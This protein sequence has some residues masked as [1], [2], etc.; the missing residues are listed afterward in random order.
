MVLRWQWACSSSSAATRP[1]LSRD[2]PLIFLHIVSRSSLGG[3]TGCVR[4]YSVPHLSSYQ[5]LP[6]QLSHW[7]EVTVVGEWVRRM[8]TTCPSLLWSSSQ[9]GSWTCDPSVVSKVP[10]IDWLIIGWLSDWLTDRLIIGLDLV[11][12]LVGW[13]LVY[14]DW[15]VDHWLVLLD[16]HRGWY[17]RSTGGSH[18]HWQTGAVCLSVLCPRWMCEFS[19]WCVPL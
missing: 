8:W 18:I 1:E 10:L 13:L 2:F 3:A 7:Y 5:P 9:G 15:L 16:W 4:S 14:T 11:G 19:V 6:S 17:T 12:W